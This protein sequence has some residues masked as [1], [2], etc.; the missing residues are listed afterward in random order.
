MYGTLVPERTVR[1]EE[2][3]EA[4]KAAEAKQNKDRKKKK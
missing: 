2:A 4:M 1:D 3:N